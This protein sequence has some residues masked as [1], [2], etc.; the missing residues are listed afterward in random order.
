MDA[1]A[2]LVSAL[3][4]LPGIG[5][6]TAQ[7]MMYKLLAQPGR[8]HAL[9]LAKCLH[10]A[11]HDIVNCSLC[12]NYTTQTICAICSQKSRDVSLL[13]VVESPADIA[14]IEHTG[15]YNGYYYVLIGKISPIDGIGP[16]QIALAG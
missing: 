7:R 1:M 2:Q 3:R 5:P 16:E 4:C 12:N 9:Q 8:T 6:K 15:L 10:T 13:C 14:A 11:M